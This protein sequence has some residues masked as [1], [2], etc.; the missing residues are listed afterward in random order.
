M[1]PKEARNPGRS[2]RGFRVSLGRAIVAALLSLLLAVAAVGSE[3]DRLPSVHG[4]ALA[5]LSSPHAALAAPER[6]TWTRAAGETRK[7]DSADGLTPVTVAGTVGA[8][9][10]AWKTVPTTQPRLECRIA[11]CARA[12]PAS[13][14]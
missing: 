8:R 6:A 9:T 12:P 11:P 2:R 1:R 10:L 4:P 7:D 5:G 3:A 13:A 14:A